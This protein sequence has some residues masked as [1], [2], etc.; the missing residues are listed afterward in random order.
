MPILVTEHY[1]RGLGVTMPEIRALLDRVTP[2]EK[3]HFSCDGNAEFRQAL[4]GLNRDQVVLCGIESHVCVYQTARDLMD[5][6][7]QVAVAA[8][9]VS[10]RFA[11]DRQIG[12]DHMR[13]IGVQIMNVEMVLFEIL[14]EAKTPDFKN[15]APILKGD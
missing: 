12:L 4:D 2:I 6:G 5:R 3:L 1:S 8:D 10:A 7:K 14:R 11:A 9:A 13:Q 15:L